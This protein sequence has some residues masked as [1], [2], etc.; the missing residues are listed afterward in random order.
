[1]AKRRDRAGMTRGFMTVG[2]WTAMS[3]LLGFVRDLMIAAILGAGPVAD[4]FF[5]AFRLP[6][7]FRR[8][9]AE[10]AF[11]S[12]FVPLFAKRLEGS[13]LAAARIFAEEALA[14]LS[15]VLLIMTALATAFMPAL[16]YA[17]AVGFA[18]DP[19]RFDLAVVYGRIQ[20]PYLLCMSLTALFSGVLN[21]LGRF[22]A[23]AAAPVLLNVILI[24]MMALAV[25]S[26]LEPGLMLAI[27]VPLAGLAQVAL[28]AIAATKAG[29]G[30]RP[31]RPRL[32]PDV[33]RLVKLGVPAAIAGGVLQINI[34]IGT[35]IASFFDGAVSWLSYADRLY[36][37]PLGLVG[38][39]IGVVLLPELSRRV[40]AD[41][42]RGA[43]EALNRATEFAMVLTVPAAVALVAMP[44][45]IV[46]TLFERGA[47]GP[48][49]SAA[50]AAAIA[51]F[52]IGLPAFVQQKVTQPAFFAR[53]NTLAP[54]RYAA[55]AVVVNIALSL[56][57]M[58]VLGYLAI[59]L[60]TSIGGWVHLFLLMRGAR[61][62]GRE[63]VMDR[64][65][66]RRL[67]RIV[68]ASAIMGVVVWALESRVLP[69]LMSE[70][71]KRWIALALGV[72]AGLL[73][74]AYAARRLG[75][76][77]WRELRGALRRG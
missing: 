29:I 37:L 68:L 12:A 16:I 50:V 70:D 11:N 64:R 71:D 19:T 25:S 32:T 76:I 15:T 77:D 49:D 63:V 44:E 7:M 26:T 75:A 10:G 3:R 58:P 46:A 62:Y 9:L 52:A 1:M 20:F 14:V 55:M 43:R 28:V 65:L 21:A 60:A 66:R 59:P 38:I 5:V 67:P 72:L 74:Y 8:F 48:D 33:R 22:G 73:T 6:N 2:A 18:D 57:A 24:A 54:M 39:A 36:Q 69:P 4:A 47:F 53:E 35:I 61:A 23:P 45:L 13:G 41:D 56:A 40:R 51:L 42:R 27:G 30:L 31:R 34:L 17:L